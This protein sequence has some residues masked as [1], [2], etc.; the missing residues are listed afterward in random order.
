MM[1]TMSGQPG[2]GCTDP[3]TYHR[4]WCG[5]CGA[6]MMFSAECCRD[7]AIIPPCPRCGSQDWRDDIDEMFAPDFHEPG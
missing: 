7:L 5:F 3:R 6:E 2:A 1:T 4:H